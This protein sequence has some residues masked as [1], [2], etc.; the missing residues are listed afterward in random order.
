MPVQVVLIIIYLTYPSVIYVIKNGECEENSVSEE[1]TIII[2]KFS[3]KLTII[4]KNVKFFLKL[5]HNFV[6]LSRLDNN[7]SVIH[8]GI[9]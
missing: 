1:S 7:Q 8:L 6:L 3:I 9:S 4:S 2:M 5:Y